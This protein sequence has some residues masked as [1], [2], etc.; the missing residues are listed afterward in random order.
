MS[1]LLLLPTTAAATTTKTTKNSSSN[2]SS[3]SNS[4]D[5]S[6]SNNNHNGNGNSNQD[7]NRH[8]APYSIS[9][10]PYSSPTSWSSSF[11]RSKATPMGVVDCTC[12]APTRSWARGRPLLHP[13]PPLPPPPCVHCATAP[14]TLRLRAIPYDHLLEPPA[15]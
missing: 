3:S 10:I 12:A 14:R 2:N 6:K 1:L 7:S 8:G 4:S 13:L 5:N 15:A 11:L 9:C